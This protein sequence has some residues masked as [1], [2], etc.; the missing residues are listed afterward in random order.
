MTTLY[1][2]E[3]ALRNAHAAGDTESA[4]RLAAAYAERKA[5]LPQDVS[6]KSQ[7]T[8]SFGQNLV[9]GFGKA[10]VDT[11]R[12]LKQLG[13][14][15]GNKAG[16]VSDATVQ[17]IQSDIDEAKQ[18]DA[19]L[20]ATGGGVTGNIVGQGVQYAVPATGVLKVAPGAVK[21]AQA[22]RGGQY[23][24][25]AAGGAT[26]AATQP[27]A[28]GDSRLENATLGA[29]GGAGGQLG[30]NTV[31]AAVRGA[32]NAIRP[33]VKNLAAR[34][35]DLGIDLRA[36]QVVNSKPMN[37]L[38][39]ALDYVPFSGNA[40]AK[41]A[42]GKQF[43]TALSRTVG[44]NT[45]NMAQA[46]K[47]ADVRLGAEFDRTLQNNHVQYTPQF[48][49]RLTQLLNAAD[50]ELTDQQ[51][52]V[53][54]KQVANLQSKVG[55]GSAI[56][57]QAAYN[58]KKSLDRL[59]KSPDTSIS[60]HA[61]EVRNALFDALDSSLGPKKAAEFAKVRQQWANKSEL[62]KMIPHGAEA[63]I[64]PARLAAARNLRSDDLGELADIAGQFLK[65]RIGD[66]G[67]AQRAAWLGGVPGAAAAVGSGAIDAGTLGAM[68]LGGL[69]LGRAASGALGSNR[70]MQYL[71]QGA[72]SLTRLE[73]PAR[74][75]LPGA[76]A[77]IA[78]YIGN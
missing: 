36:D 35:K 2:L 59:A 13:A 68:S 60:H 18:L 42:Q 19:P 20:M 67:T 23:L 56:D 14:Q 37:A 61:K 62:E 70:L 9:A 73:A 27:V 78:P 34:A 40:A 47:S 28:T 45:D 48:H 10:F 12:G 46:L 74:A 52:G 75:V 5:A 16:L 3:T 7:V 31:S 26:F 72:P 51:F 8:G 49:T 33:E 71:Q 15:I 57:G 4:Q 41:Q 24:L 63:D 17:G 58:I 54:A 69:T 44:E 29:V 50:S 39:A 30:A 65:G 43:Q 22:V 76:G 25:P 21:A 32:S 77:L 6:E 38:S 53:I 66:S 64:T 1:Q 11:G 55:A